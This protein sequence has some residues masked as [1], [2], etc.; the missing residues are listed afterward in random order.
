[1]NQ[2][3]IS[4]QNLTKRFASGHYALRD[5]SFD[6]F[7]GECFGLIGKSGAGKSTLIRALLGLTKPNKGKIYIDGS[8]LDPQKRSKEIAMVFQQYNLYDSRTALNN[9]A[10]PLELEG[11]SKKEREEKAFRCLQSVGMEERAH[12]YPAQLS[13]GEKQRVSIARAL[14][15]NPKILLCDEPTSA[16]DPHTTDSLLQL[17]KQLNESRGLTILMITHEMDVIKQICTHVGVLD[18]GKLVEKGKVVDLLL[19]PNHSVTQDFLHTIQ[20]DL[21]SL[22][23]LSFE[24]SEKIRL[25]FPS[26][27]VQKPLMSQLIRKFDLD[28]NILLGAIDVLKEDTIGNLIVSLSGDETKRS[29]AKEYLIEQGVYCEEISE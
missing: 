5:V 7:A 11:V 24:Q 13:G 15:S 27:S 8:L 12:R 22:S 14:I 21:S 17:L 1:M 4:I 9:V 3:F 29:L 10:F 25:C 19:R 16:L 28:V 18:Q 20:K 2:P 6:V 26:H 23:G